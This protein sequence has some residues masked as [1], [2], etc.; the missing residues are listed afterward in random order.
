M[1]QRQGTSWPEIVQWLWRKFNSTCDLHAWFA[2]VSARRTEEEEEKS[3]TSSVTEKTEVIDQSH[4]GDG[5]AG[6]QL[7]YSWGKHWLISSTQ[8]FLASAPPAGTMQGELPF[9]SSMSL[10]FSPKPKARCDCAT[11]TFCSSASTRAHKHTAS[12][13]E[14]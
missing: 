9:L 10:L 4:Q 11:E 1:C 6:F 3:M 12:K 7:L 8:L 2:S 5:G 13:K 14:R